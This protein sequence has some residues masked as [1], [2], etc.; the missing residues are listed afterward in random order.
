MVELQDSDFCD[1]M[2]SRSEEGHSQK[3]AP[4]PCKRG[5]LPPTAFLSSVPREGPELSPCRPARGPSVCSLPLGRQHPCYLTLHPE[6]QG[7][8]LGTGIP[9][10]SCFGFWRDYSVRED[11]LG[12]VSAFNLEMNAD[13]DEV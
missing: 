13:V 4:P 12:P 10:L 1:G 5:H 9:G 7:L 3:D 6:V 8:P 2:L 11:A